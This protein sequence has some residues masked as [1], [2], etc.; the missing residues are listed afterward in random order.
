MAYT[1]EKYAALLYVIQQTEQSAS[2]SLCDYRYSH[3]I[4][5]SYASQQYG[6][7][8]AFLFSCDTSRNC[9]QKRRQQIFS[10][11][12][13]LYIENGKEPFEACFASSTDKD[14]VNML[15]DTCKKN[16]H[17]LLPIGYMYMYLFPNISKNLLKGT[18]C[19]HN[20]QVF[21]TDCAL[22]SCTYMSYMYTHKNGTCSYRR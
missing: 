7:S 12:K 21:N 4:L 18:C 1:K 6:S 10:S 20:M 17:N 14:I 9:I 16:Q 19:S 15:Q 5:R 8:D 13:N 3:P 11:C 22:Y 2:C